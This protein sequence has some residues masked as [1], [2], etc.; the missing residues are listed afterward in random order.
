MDYILDHKKDSVFTQTGG[1]LL[2]NIF[3]ALGNLL[4]GKGEL[5]KSLEGNSLLGLLKYILGMSL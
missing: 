4:A 1:L 2:P 5:I 3:G